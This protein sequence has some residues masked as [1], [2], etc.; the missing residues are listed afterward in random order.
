MWSSESIW[1]PLTLDS[2]EALNPIESLLEQEGE[3]RFGDF[4][5]KIILTHQEFR[6]I[7]QFNKFPIL[8]ADVI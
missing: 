1:S 6:Q 4:V 8:Q 3:Y 2:V 7:L 5:A